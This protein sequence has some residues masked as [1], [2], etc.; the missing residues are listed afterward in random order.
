MLRGLVCSVLAALTATPAAALTVS[1]REGVNGYTATTPASFSFDGTLADDT[2]RID[3]SNAS[4]PADSFAWLLFEKLVG[5]GAVPTGATVLSATLTGWVTNPF[6]SASLSFLL[7]E[8]ASRPSGPGANVFDASGS[9]YD[10][11][12]LSASHP[13]GCATS[14]SAI[15]PSR[16]SGT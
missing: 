8:I 5:A 13:G 3:I 10:A 4:H 14:S 6:G 16:S 7:D 2:L 1:F 15:P 9:F 11:N 12:L